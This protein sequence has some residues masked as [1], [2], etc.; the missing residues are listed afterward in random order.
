M[1]G[2]HLSMHSSIQIKTMNR[3][4]FWCQAL[5]TQSGQVPRDAGVERGRVSGARGAWQPVPR[6]VSFQWD[7]AKSPCGFLGITLRECRLERGTLL[8]AIISLLLIVVFAALGSSWGLQPL[9][10]PPGGRVS[11]R[12][13]LKCVFYFTDKL[14]TCLCLFRGRE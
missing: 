7:D 14:K 10:F 6:E 4:R 5:R 13:N 2:P 9:S 1:L 3:G 11:L 12:R 8:P